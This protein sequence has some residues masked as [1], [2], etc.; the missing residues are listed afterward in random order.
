MV[1]LSSG[2]SGMGGDVGEVRK[3]LQ[4]CRDGSGNGCRDEGMDGY[5]DRLDVGLCPQPIPCLWEASASPSA[6][7]LCSP[8]VSWVLG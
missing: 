3:R 4:E 1:G 7:R 8:R 5:G 6:R 2:P